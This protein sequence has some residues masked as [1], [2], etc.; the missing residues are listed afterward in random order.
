M[1]TRKGAEEGVAPEATATPKA[2]D[3]KMSATIGADVCTQ[4]CV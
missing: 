1:M 4:L 2:E 3:V